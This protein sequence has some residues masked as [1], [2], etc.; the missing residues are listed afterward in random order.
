MN[1]DFK[2]EQKIKLKKTKKINILSV[3]DDYMNQVANKNFI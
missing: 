1:N 2:E 3:D